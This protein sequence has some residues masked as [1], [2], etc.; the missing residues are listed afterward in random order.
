MSLIY[1]FFICESDCK[2]FFRMSKVILKSD[3]LKIDI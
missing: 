2:I 3:R 1:Q